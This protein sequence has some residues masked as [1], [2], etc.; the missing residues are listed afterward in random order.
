[1]RLRRYVIGCERLYV[2][3]H[4][5]PDLYSSVCDWITLRIVW[6]ERRLDDAR[7]CAIYTQDTPGTLG[8]KL[9]ELGREL[10]AVRVWRGCGG[11][12]LRGMGRR[13]RG[14]GVEER[15]SSHAT[16]L[17]WVLL[18]ASPPPLPSA[19][20][21]PQDINAIAARQRKQALEA[22]E[23]GSTNGSQSPDRAGHARKAQALPRG[24]LQARK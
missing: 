5:C 23:A 13:G 20:R 6:T 3:A 21:A 2:D 24:S 7:L 17:S 11:G 4:F 8:A 14:R 10:L 16:F 19:P 22:A 18:G 1:M 9:G 15:A 12:R